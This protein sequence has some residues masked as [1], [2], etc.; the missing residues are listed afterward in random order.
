MSAYGDYMDKYGATD[1][2]DEDTAR[3]LYTHEDAEEYNGDQP[4][5]DEE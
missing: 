5:Q 4:E 1:E 3:E 2:Y